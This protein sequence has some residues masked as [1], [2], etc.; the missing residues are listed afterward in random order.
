MTILQIHQNIAA[1]DAIGNDIEMI[2]KITGRYAISVCY[3]ETGT[4]RAVPWVDSIQA[5]RILADE[6]S[7]VIYHHSVFW[8]LGEKMLENARARIIIR[9]HNITPPDFFAPYAGGHYAQCVRGRAQTDRLQEK[10]PQAFWLC[11]SEYNSSEIKQ[12][13]S[14]QKAVLAPFSKIETW[15]RVR[16]DEKVLKRMVY[17]GNTHFLFVGRT[18]PNKG[19]LK[20][21]EVLYW[22][23]RFYDK[24]TDMYIIG[25]F[26][27]SL[28]VYNQQLI[29]RIRHFGLSKNVHFVGEIND[30]S[31]KAYYLASD[32]YLNLSEHEGFCVPLNEAQYFEL[33]I[34]ARKSTAVPETMGDKQ[35]IL[36]E[37]TLEYAA[38]AHVVL[39]DKALKAQLCRY[40]K[41]NFETRFTNAELDKKLIDILKNR[42]GVLV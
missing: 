5:R 2:A 41:E 25:K 20:L 13:P 38:A 18:A 34:L 26:D 15:G 11:D 42:I 10:F 22:Y 17:S 33:P 31:L 16:P 27:D 12:I 3:G 30:A 24:N 9:Y 19:H 32:L 28:A 29:D 14:E 1:H 8:E 7:I 6:D 39:K 21:V 37:D 35:I 40:G 36:G 23:R 4:N